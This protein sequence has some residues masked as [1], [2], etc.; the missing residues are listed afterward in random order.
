MLTLAFDTATE[1]ATIALLE[2]DDVLGE[3]RTVAKRVLADAQTIL[4]R[5]ARAIG[6]V[7]RIV[8]GV[9]PGSFTSIRIGIAAARGLALALGIPAAGVSTLDALAC[10][11]PNVFPV[12][13]ARRR[14]V[15][16]SGPAAVEPARLAVPTGALCVGD[17]AVRYRDVLEALGGV[18]PPDD[19]DLHVPWARFHATL[20]GRF[21]SFG[22]AEQVEPV[23]VREPDA[24]HLFG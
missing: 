9:G 21:G 15:F 1:V 17:G 20:A 10:G 16:V 22:D 5:A 8:V 6:D 12:I 3:R 4:D 24:A 13:D 11:A 14:E 2:G 19:S 18:V 7:D 23:Y